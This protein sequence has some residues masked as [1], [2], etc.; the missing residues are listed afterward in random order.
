MEVRKMGHLSAPE[1]THRI[2]E[3]WDQAGPGYFLIALSFLGFLWLEKRLPPPGYAITAMAVIAG[4]M[5]LRP[6]MGGWEKSLW[7]VILLLFAGI[8]IRAISRDRK[9]Q[10]KTF[11]DIASQLAVTVNQGTTAL[12][13]LN[14]TI[15]EGRTHF[16]STM[17]GLT[18]SVKTQTGGDSFCYLEFSQALNDVGGMTLVKVGKYP[19]RGVS[20]TIMDAAKT[21]AA[22]NEFVKANPPKGDQD[23]ANHVFAIQRM[24]EVLQPVPDFATDTRFLGGYQMTKS[25]RQSFQILFGAFNGSWIERMEIRTVNG[26]WAKAIMVEVPMTKKYRHFY[27][28]PDYPRVNGKLD[29]PSWPRPAHGEPEWEK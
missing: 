2:R 1:W 6:D 8:E 27:I 10:T 18:D 22:V 15:K 3:I 21:A 19:L 13:A 24:S 29:V 26:K 16:D 14:E 23:Y 11:S 12:N 9:E 4:V 25:D 20:A 17:S 28:D 7:F 5:A